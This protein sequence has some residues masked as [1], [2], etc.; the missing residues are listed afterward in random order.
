MSNVM[1][2]LVQAPMPPSH[3]TS[4]GFASPTTFAQEDEDLTLDGTGELEEEEAQEVEEDDVG[5]W[6]CCHHISS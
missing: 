4:S 5:L 2:P 6:P 3:P 1:R